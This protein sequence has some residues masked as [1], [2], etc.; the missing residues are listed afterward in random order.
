VFVPDLQ[1]RPP[2]LP[3]LGVRAAR[4]A[5]AAHPDDANAWWVLALATLYLDRTTT[6]SATPVRLAPLAEVRSIQIATALRQA[7]TLKPDLA[8]AHDKLAL[9]FRDRGYLDLALHHRK[10]QLQLTRD[11]GR[12]PG[13]DSADFKERLAQLE[14]SVEQMQATV[15]TSE[16]RFTVHGQALAA[17]PLARARLAVELG[18]AGKALDDVLLKSDPDLYGKPGLRLLLELLLGTGRAQEARILLDREELRRNPEGLGD[19]M[20]MASRLDGQRWGYLFS[21]SAYD[22]FDLCQAAAAGHYGHATR[23]LERLRRP[24]EEKGDQARAY[25][26]DQL[27]WRVPAE[28]G[29]VVT[30]PP[31]GLRLW[32]TLQRE[33]TAAQLVQSHF[34]PVERADLHALEAML[35]LEWGRSGEAAE[36]FRHALAL[37]DQADDTVPARPGVDLV[38]RYLARMQA[39]AQ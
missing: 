2:A 28:M 38:R 7:I 15:D 13:E 39:L 32:A 5:V 23:T 30:P 16:N 6:E 4:R 26:E 29:L 22:W 18:L 24:L 31:I 11:A 20:L 37:Y 10:I 3:L 1:E 8:V 14:R 35:L 21:D 36:Q 12:L 19:H 25:L 9:L 34:V 33:L 17:D 27:K